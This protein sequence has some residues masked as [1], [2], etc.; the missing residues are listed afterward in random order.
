MYYRVMAGFGDH[1]TTDKDSY[2]VSIYVS[3]SL[4]KNMLDC[5]SLMIKS[6]ANNLYVGGGESHSIIIHVKS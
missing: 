4:L 6:G 2:Y 1:S 3:I 5:L